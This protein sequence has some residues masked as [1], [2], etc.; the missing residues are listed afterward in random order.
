M[1]ASAR[2]AVGAVVIG[3]NEGPRLERCLR[4]LAPDVARIV[5]VDSGSTDDS[6]A[7]A[8]RVG[9][10]IVELDAAHPFTMARARNAGLRR[11]EELDP[12]VE[13]VQ[14]V[15]GDCEVRPGWVERA[16]AHLESHPDV[17]VVCGRR[18]ERFP[19]ASLYN[20][21]IDL[22][23]DGPTGDVAA[24]GGDAMMRA[25]A[26]RTCG[27]FDPVMIAGEEPE[28]CCRLRLAGWR[29]VRLA[30][31]MTLHDAK[32]MRFGQWW[33]RAVRGGHAFAEGARMHGHSP[34]RH[35]VRQLR[36]VALWGLG[37]PGAI[38]TCLLLGAVAAGADRQVAATVCAL[39]ALLLALSYPILALRIYRRRRAAG[40]DRSEAG[41][42]AVF[43]VLGKFA[44]AVG[45]LRFQRSRN[46]VR[47]LIEYR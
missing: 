35:N 23:W 28:L 12:A 4:S 14:F 10:E 42:Y 2:A 27:A 44:E 15:D 32:L 8:R 25:Q 31:E 46:R 45:A 18:R 43:C 7:I 17:A 24:C 9:A 20:R 39:G 37:I 22:E 19:H 33:T 1:G 41:L 11:L 6:L 47:H 34:L 5:Y 3:R 26:L 36:S 30:A 21:L 16:R 40:S 29:V 13:L 38:V